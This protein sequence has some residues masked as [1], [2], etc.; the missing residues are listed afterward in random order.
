MLI[1]EQASSGTQWCLCIS[2]PRYLKPVGIRRALGTCRPITMLISEQASSG[3]QWCLCISTPRYLMPVSTQAGFGHMSAHH[4][5]RQRA[6]YTRSSALPTQISHPPVH[7]TPQNAGTTAVTPWHVRTKA[8]SQ[9]YY[10][11]SHTGSHTEQQP[12]RLT[13]SL[14]PEHSAPT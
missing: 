4:N 8:R 12:H 10:N 2:M 3:T 9:T 11:S 7:T 5:A 14:A 13:H 1:S 6:R